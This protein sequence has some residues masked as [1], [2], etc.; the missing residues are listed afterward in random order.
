MYTI[1]FVGL[2]IISGFFLF[3]GLKTKK[4]SS[5]AIGI[6]LA[7]ATIIFFWFMGFW[8]E[9]LW[10]DSI[11]YTGRFWREI[12]VKAGA[13]LIGLVFS[14]AVILPFALLVPIPPQTGLPKKLLRAVPLVIAGLI[15]A[16][17]GAGNWD[18]IF[19]FFYRQA[20]GFTEPILNMDAGFFMFS[21]PFMELLYSHLL[22]LSVIAIIVTFLPLYAYT[23]RVLIQNRAGGSS[24]RNVSPQNAGPQSSDSGG[25]SG[26]FAYHDGS[27]RPTARPFRRSRR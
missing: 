8:G 26:S 18:L 22:L 15:G 3:R 5:I 17:K 16:A 12:L 25:G 11:G 20:T 27:C 1:I 19:R 10:F 14:V 21:L 23:Q 4:K 9:K 6:T 7:L 13:G 2:L 24:E